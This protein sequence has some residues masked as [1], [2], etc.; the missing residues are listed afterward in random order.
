MAAQGEAEVE[1]MGRPRAR[2]PDF[3]SLFPKTENSLYF[4]H[5]GVLSKISFR[6]KEK[7]QYHSEKK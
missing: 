3:Q 2:D 7:I 5:I 4:F 6:G 1:E